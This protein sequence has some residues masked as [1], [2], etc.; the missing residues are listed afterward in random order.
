M[1][2]EPKPT[3]PAPLTAA[4]PLLSP[5]RLFTGLLALAMALSAVLFA[6]QLTRQY[7]FP[8]AFQDGIGSP[9]LALEL[10]SN[11]QDLKGV[12]GT[13]S[14]AQ[15]VPTTNAAAAVA[16]LRTNT[17]EDFFFIVLYTAYLWHFASLFA[18]GADGAPRVYR[19]AIGG[20]AILIALFDCA[21]KVGMLSA[22]NAFSFSD[23]TAQAICLPSRLKWGFFALG[24]LLTAWILAR[25]QS[26]IYS[27]PTRRLLVLAYAMAGVLLLVGLFQPHVIEL[28]THVFAVLV[29]INIVGLLGPYV[30]RRWLRPRRPI[31]VDN[32]CHRTKQAPQDVAVYPE[33]DVSEGGRA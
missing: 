21:E 12:L 23:A 11:A 18:V 6:S 24:L 26:M 7:P 32:F 14:P 16:S 1:A 13:G 31:Y 28:A 25:S 30:E 33:P 27:L 10:S 19:R 9:V 15:V 22:L 2:A 3:E 29:A 4:E 17:Y 8:H 20:I 5:Q